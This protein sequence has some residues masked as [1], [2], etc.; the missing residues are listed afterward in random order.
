MPM[1]EI[2]PALNAD[3]WGQWRRLAQYIF[4][5]DGHGHATVIQRN[6]IEV[7][8]RHAIAALSLHGQPFGFTREDVALLRD[9]AGDYEG[10][11][12]YFPEGQRLLSLADRLA[13]L[14]PPERP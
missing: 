2:A 14:L 9:M 1:P 12:G 3:E 4:T 8:R 11:N 7:P 6:A 13:A 5:S 10:R